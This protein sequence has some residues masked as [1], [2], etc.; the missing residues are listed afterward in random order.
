M[1]AFYIVNPDEAATNTPTVNQKFIFMNSPHP[2]VAIYFTITDL[3]IFPI[4]SF[5]ATLYSGVISYFGIVL[6]ILLIVAMQQMKSLI[7][8]DLKTFRKEDL[9]LF[10]GGWYSNITAPLTLSVQGPTTDVK[11]VKF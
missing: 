7:V 6:F 2:M 11:D 5:I 10:Y 9:S 3:S 8:F 4:L 1:R